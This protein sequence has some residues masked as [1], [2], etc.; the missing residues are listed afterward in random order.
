MNAKEPNITLI[1]GSTTAV[2]ARLIAALFLLETIYAALIILFIV[3]SSQIQVGTQLILILWLAHTAKFLAASYFVVRILT[4]TLSRK[5][6]VTKHHLVVDSGLFTI[7]E[8]VYELNQLRRIKIHQNTIGKRLG[9]GNIELKF[10][11]RG[12]DKTIYLPYVSA[13]RNYSDIFEEYLK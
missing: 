11:D 9:Y 12:F 5:S 2:I 4:E 8:E 7:D 1:K 10:G 13:P 3:L 6:Y